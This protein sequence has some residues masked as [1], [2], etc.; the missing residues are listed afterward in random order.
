M[1][2]CL[3]ELKAMCAFGSISWQCRSSESAAQCRPKLLETVSSIENRGP[4]VILSS[5]LRVQL[6]RFSA[7]LSSDGCSAV[8]RL[9]CADSSSRSY[10]NPSQFTLESPT[11]S[12]LHRPRRTL[13]TRRYFPRPTSLFP[14]GSLTPGISFDSSTLGFRRGFFLRLGAA[15]QLSQYQPNFL[16]TLP[17]IVC[18]D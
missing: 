7:A 15:F 10:P 6:F 13:F 1:G 9:V 4:Q 18:L 12:R 14:S 17:A 3:A 16:H 2:E 5:L 8:R 11:S